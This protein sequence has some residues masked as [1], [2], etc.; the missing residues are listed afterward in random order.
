MDFLRENVG[1]W[2]YP[3]LF[4]VTF[5]ETSAFL[6]LVSPGEATVVVCGLLASRGPLDLG[7]VLAL[8]ILGAYGG[9]T[10][11]YWIGRRFGTRVLE[12]WGRFA[13]F[14]RGTQEAVRRYY[15]RHGGKTVFLGRFASIVRS[16]GPMVAGSSGMPYG[17][18]ALWS[19]LGCVAWGTVFS[20]V[21]YFF[22]ESWEIIDRYLGRVGVIGFV[23]GAAV[24][25]VYLFL[26]RRRRAVP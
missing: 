21:G 18:F 11:G 14:D 22:G 5:L 16:F 7:W 9:D 17:V 8:S 25:V 6:G 23:A 3:F 15:E 2:G 10:A 20:L 1:R 26:R 19:A 24:F 13:F 4:V 12:R